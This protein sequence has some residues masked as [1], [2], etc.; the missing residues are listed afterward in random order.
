MEILKQRILKEGRVLPG[1]ILKIDSFLNHQI[2]TALMSEIGREFAGRFAGETVTRILTV[3]ASGIA[4]ALT[5]AQQFGSCPV[6]FAKK[7]GAANMSA[8]VYHAPLH[9]YTRNRDL[10]IFVSRQYLSES[11]RVLIIDDFLA[12]GQALKALTEIIRQAGS[13]LVGCGVV[14]E[15]AYQPGGQMLRDQGI[16]VESLARIAAMDPE[17][18]ITFSE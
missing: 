13:T 8:E 17:T 7:G 16:R 6:V 12:N 9:S 11:D 18:G 14:V 2:D 4:A 3:E 15:K 5:T 1:D 10:E